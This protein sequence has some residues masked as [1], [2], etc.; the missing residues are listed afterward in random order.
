M[1]RPRVAARVWVAFWSRRSCRRRNG[2]YRE[3]RLDTLPTMTEAAA[4]YRS[5]GFA[6]IPAYYDTPIAGTLFLSRSV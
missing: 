6:P 3:V 5:M 4:L 2:S 1:W